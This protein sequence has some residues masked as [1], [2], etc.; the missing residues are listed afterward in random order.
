MSFFKE[1]ILEK[2]VYWVCDKTNCG[3]KNYRLIFIYDNS[4][5]PSP[6]SIYNDDVCD[7]CCQYIHEPLFVEHTII[8]KENDNS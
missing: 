4:L 5:R 2:H 1:P 6:Y 8:K 3:N 7:Q